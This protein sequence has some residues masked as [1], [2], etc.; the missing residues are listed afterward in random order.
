MMPLP[1]GVEERLRGLEARTDGKDGLRL[2]AADGTATFYPDGLAAVPASKKLA[3]RAAVALWLASAG[4]VVFCVLS[5]RAGGVDRWLWLAAAGALVVAALAMA[6]RGRWQRVRPVAKTGV[7]IV[8]EGLLRI[9]PAGLSFTPRDDIVDVERRER[10]LFVTRRS[11]DA[12]PWLFY[13]GYWAE[14]RELV[15]RKWLKSQRL[16]PGPPPVSGA[17][18]LVTS[19]ATWLAMPA[20]L[21]LFL[22]L[23][24]VMPTTS[25]QGEA[26]RTFLAHTR[27]GELDDAWAQLTPALQAAVAPARFAASL[28]AHLRDHDAVTVNGVSGGLGLGG[29]SACVDGWVTSARGREGFVLFLEEHGGAWRIADYSGARGCR[30][31]S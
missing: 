29:T 4:L 28:P 13:E 10:Q 11:P 6:L 7:A 18:R 20:A 23:G 26:A 22:W 25:A 1:S 31:P 15:V 16:D 2:R 9:D 14:P 8:P 5:L 17:A 27:A 12:A 30:R 19:F 24:L 3:A 21:S